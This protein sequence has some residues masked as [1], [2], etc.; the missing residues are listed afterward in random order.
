MVSERCIT[1][2]SVYIYDRGGMTRVGVIKDIESIRW[3][4]N[5]DGVSEAQIIVAGRS[6]QNQRRLI[7]S[8]ITKR[9]EMVIYRE[10]V[11]VWEGPLWRIGDEGTRVIIVAHDVSEYLFGTPLTKVWDNSY[12]NDND[13]SR[14]TEVTRRMESIIVHE[15]TASRTVRKVGGGTVVMPAWESLDP[16]AN[17]LPFLDFH[18]FP[19]EARTAAKT[20]AYEMTV[21]EHLQNLC[22]TGG[23]DYTTVG[24]A[25]HLWDTSRSIGRL[26]AWTE[27]DFFGNI[28]ISEY[29]A[30]H[31]QSAYVMSQDGVYGEAGVENYLDIYGP[32]TKIVD[33]FNEEGT[34]APTETELDS[35][36]TRNLSSRQPVPIEVRVPDNSSVRLGD[37][38]SI[39]DLGPGGGR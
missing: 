38:L 36:A 17:I 5:R 25:I 15:L 14:A 11:R 32:W 28:I 3:E 4:R 37:T 1:G 20:L 9:H 7:S 13:V 27:A 12:D 39:N 34:E 31:A 29:G 16:P 22:R 23:I 24:R 19:N 10:G 26:R 30:D 6:C 2:H 8:L 21:G 33:A 35:Q 18:H